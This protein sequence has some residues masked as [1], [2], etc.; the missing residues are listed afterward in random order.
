MSL[1][2]YQQF[3]NCYFKNNLPRVGTVGVLSAADGSIHPAC[4]FSPQIA[5]PILAA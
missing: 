2:G 3:F 5:D 4:I 1:N